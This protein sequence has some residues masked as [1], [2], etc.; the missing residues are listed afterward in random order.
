MRQFLG[1]RDVFRLLEYVFRGPD[2]SEREILTPKQCR[3]FV[4]DIL[5]KRDCLLP[6]LAPNAMIANMFDTTE[7]QRQLL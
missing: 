5:I 3:F 4:G 7:M 2:H 1:A 6:N